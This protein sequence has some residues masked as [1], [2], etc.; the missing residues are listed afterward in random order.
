MQK[1]VRWVLRQHWPTRITRQLGTLFLVII[2]GDLEVDQQ[3]HNPLEVLLLDLSV[4]HH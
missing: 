1:T 2:S 3:S 4:L